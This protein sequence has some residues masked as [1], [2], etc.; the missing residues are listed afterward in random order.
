M[1]LAKAKANPPTPTKPAKAS[2]NKD[3]KNWPVEKVCAWMEKQGELA[4][5]KDVIESN[6]LTGSDL[7]DLERED[8]KTVLNIVNFKHRKVLYEALT[9]FRDEPTTGSATPS[10]E[11]EKAQADK[12]NVA[13]EDNSKDK[14]TPTKEKKK[15]VT[16]KPKI[17]NKLGSIKKTGDSIKKQS[18]KDSKDSSK[19]AKKSPL[20]K[21]SKE[22]KDKG[23]KKEKKKKKEKDENAPKRALSAYFIFSGEK[24]EEIKKAN[25]EAGI[26]DIAKLISA[27]WNKL[28]DDQKKPFQQQADK[29]KARYETEMTE[30]KKNNPDAVV[31]SSKKK[32]DKTPKK[33][34]GKAKKEKR[35]K[36][37]SDSPVERRQSS[38]RK[39][40]SPLAAQQDEGSASEMEEEDDA[41]YMGGAANFCLIMEA[42]ARD[43][44]VH[45]SAPEWGTRSVEIFQ[46]LEQIGEGTYGKVYKARNKVSNEIVALK[47]INM[48]NEKEGFPITAIRE[49][50]I[51]KRLNHP[52]VV[53]LLEIV[54]SKATEYNKKRGSVYMVFEYMDH[55]L[56]GLIDMRP[57]INFTIP[58]IK[59]F[60]KQILEGL[61]YCHLNNIMHRDIKGANLLI[62]NGGVLKLADFGL[63]RPYSEQSMRYTNRVITLW[64]R[65]PEL[66]LG[67]IKYGP[68]VDMW[69]VGC[70]FSEL[71]TGRCAF[72]GQNEA[73]QVE[74]IFQVCGSPT[75]EVWPGH[76][77]LS[78]F[79][80]MRPKQD[81]KR[82]VKDHFK[83]AGVVDEQAL[84]LIDRLLALD[85]KKRISAADALHHA[86]FWTDPMPCDPR[87]LPRV[88]TACHEWQVKQKRQA[89]RGPPEAQ[90]P[91]KRHQSNHPSGTR[92]APP[93]ASQP[94]QPNLSYGAGPPHP[95]PQ[96]PFAHQPYP[97]H[98]PP[99][100]QG[101]PPSHT[102]RS[103]PYPSGG[104]PH[105]SHP[106][107]SYRDGQPPRTHPSAQ[108]H[109][110][111]PPPAQA[112]ASGSY[113]GS[114]SNQQWNSGYR[115]Q[116]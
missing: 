25:P 112:P 108:L 21:V 7:L 75:E 71:L 115:A 65:P 10:K 34:E 92:A 68:A 111:P 104:P 3:F 46:K 18:P 8:Y 37:S 106:Q 30:Y 62:S 57:R 102:H 58:Q 6:G 55:D 99:Q 40:K 91:P 35:E 20:A 38:G 67:S 77:E 96:Q 45:P 59:C 29:E 54:T 100:Y 113:Q 78:G 97:N 73:S 41:E 74:K 48:E 13:V 90:P 39:R 36:T 70:I 27:E 79:N 2:N 11:Q 4:A 85:P 5:Y 23:D 43:G 82:R 47:K 98:P 52:N 83:H 22:D 49:I 15:E 64:Y 50:K 69:S 31:S 87:D 81:Y 114:R 17:G 60:M 1:R 16:P 9:P 107:H 14:K 56:T 26:T 86:Y 44:R 116:R 66:L 76:S 28:D 80:E 32:A 88:E 53:K 42:G 24:R 51:L 109:V 12:E 89:E 101:H 95:H 19:G 61:D 84:D 103:A 93:P 94:Q 33:K 72:T 110:H 105:A 63:A